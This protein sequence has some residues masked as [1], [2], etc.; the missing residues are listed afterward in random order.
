MQLICRQTCTQ[1]KA[2][3]E[4]INFKLIYKMKNTVSKNEKLISKISKF[5]LAYIH[6]TLLDLFRQDIITRKLHNQSTQLITFLGGEDRGSETN[7]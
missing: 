1:L 6:L 5:P 3:Q 2:K 7:S 4:E